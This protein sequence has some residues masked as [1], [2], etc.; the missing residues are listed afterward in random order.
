MSDERYGGVQE[1]SHFGVTTSETG[2]CDVSGGVGHQSCL[3]ELRRS[4]SGSWKRTKLDAESNGS[5]SRML[6]ICIN[7]ADS[8]VTNHAYLRFVKLS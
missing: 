2:G 3:F 8:T 1:E 5:R 4:R 7:M 6:E